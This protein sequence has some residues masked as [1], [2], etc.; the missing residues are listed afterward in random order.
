MPE[1]TDKTGHSGPRQTSQTQ[2]NRQRGGSGGRGSH[3]FGNG[4]TNSY[5]PSRFYYPQPNS[6]RP[7]GGSGGG[8]GTPS[9]G[10]NSSRP[11]K[12]TE[13]KEQHTVDR[14]P[15]GLL[16]KRT[17]DVDEQ[18]TSGSSELAAAKAEV[19]P[20]MANAASQKTN[21]EPEQVSL[22]VSAP[23][24]SLPSHPHPSAGWHQQQQ[25]QQMMAWAYQQQ[26]Q[27]A[28]MYQ[29]FVHQNLQH[30]RK[31]QEVAAAAAATVTSGKDQ[32]EDED[33]EVKSDSDPGTVA[34]G[35]VPPPLQTRDDDDEAGLARQLE[36]MLKE[37]GVG[38]SLRAETEEVEQGEE[39]PAETATQNHLQEYSTVSQ[40]LTNFSNEQTHDDTP[41]IHRPSQDLENHDLM[42]S[43]APFADH[44]Y[45]WVADASESYERV[46][47]A[48]FSPVTADGGEHEEDQQPEPRRNKPRSQVA[49]EVGGRTFYVFPS[50]FKAYPTSRLNRILNGPNP[51]K[52][53]ARQAIP[54]DRDGYLFEWLLAFCRTGRLTIPPGVSLAAFIDEAE[55]F[56]LRKYINDDSRRKLDRYKFSFRREIRSHLSTRHEGN[57]NTKFCFSLHGDNDLLKVKEMI[58]TGNQ[59]LLVDVCNR[60]GDL[61]HSN[62]IV[63]DPRT[64]SY[65]CQTFKAGYMY[66]FKID[67]SRGAVAPANVE[68][69][70][71]EVLSFADKDQII[72]DIESR[73]KKD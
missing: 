51:V 60:N 56:G 14:R 43:S 41:F 54:F 34:P 49:L 4:G 46:E 17:D 47:R 67:N 2:T 57:R 11:T 39:F 31:Q 55:Y 70:F 53:N 25:Q 9:R 23:S 20:S 65:G 62:Y 15:P 5:R 72:A 40:P 58:P 16:E 48:R 63:Y 37:K 50:T 36:S 33:V 6:R 59:F 69:I 3:R 38:L 24:P 64:K 19:V 12:P 22:A 18:L 73:N 45:P 8:G 21:S 35:S 7:G 52:L 10:A 13:S 44:T 30:Q 26:Q 29:L 1:V 28:H 68:V 42:A 32:E 61:V 71:E 66:C 27:L